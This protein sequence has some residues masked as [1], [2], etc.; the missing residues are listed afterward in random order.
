MRIHFSPQSMHCDKLERR[1]TSLL[2][3]ADIQERIQ[4]AFRQFCQKG[5]SLLLSQLKC[6]RS[7]VCL[8]LPQSIGADAPKPGD[9]L[10]IASKQATVFRMR[11]YPSLLRISGKQPSERFE[12]RAS[13]TGQVRGRR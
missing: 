4:E 1:D 3:K 7:R 10:D 8:D 6:L 2:V 13:G 11:R 9:V 12:R 5:E